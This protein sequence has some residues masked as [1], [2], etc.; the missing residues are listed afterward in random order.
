MGQRITYNMK[1]S[2]FWSISA[3][4]STTSRNSDYSTEYPVIADFTVYSPTIERFVEDYPYFTVETYGQAVSETTFGD[5]GAGRF[6]TLTFETINFK[7]ADYRDQH[8]VSSR[9]NHFTFDVGVDIGVGFKTD[10]N[11]LLLRPFT[12]GW[13][14]SVGAK[15]RTLDFG[16][17]VT[18]ITFHPKGEVV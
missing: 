5:V 16:L 3:N 2:W 15:W 4:W 13:I 18:S 17:G 10:G 11:K 12:N 6:G 7:S 14:Y 1:Y 9:Q 8:I